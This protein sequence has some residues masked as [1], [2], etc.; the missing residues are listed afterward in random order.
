MRETIGHED[1]IELE[2]QIGPTL[3]AVLTGNRDRYVVFRWLDSMDELKPTKEEARRLAFAIEQ[4]RIVT[5]AEGVDIT[6]AWLLGSDPSGVSPLAAIRSG[7]FERVINS[8][9]RLISDT[10]Y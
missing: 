6:R 10:Y 1:L 2:R 5:K 8:A 3:I 7:D 9:Q 4:L